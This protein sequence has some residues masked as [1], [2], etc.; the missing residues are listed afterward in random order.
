MRKLKK[1]SK[2]ML[3]VYFTHLLKEKFH[4]FFKT[5]FYK[6]NCEFKERSYKFYSS[7][8]NAKDIVYDVGANFGNRVEAFIKLNAKVVAIEP[9]SA[10]CKYLRKKYKDKIMLVNKAVGSENSEKE[11]YISN[12]SAVSS[13]SKDWVESVKKDR[14][15]EQNWDKSVKCEVVTLDSLI[16]KYSVPAFIKIDVEG[17]ELEVLKGLNK[18]V[19]VISF[20]YTIPE[21][22]E[23]AIQ[24]IKHIKEI[25]GAVECNYSIGESMVLQLK[26]WISDEEMINLISDNRFPNEVGD[27]YVRRI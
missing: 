7:F 12:N 2:S 22:T 15:K 1:I 24:C 16:E 27:I 13:L 20:E 6:E 18:M 17:Y 9:Q 8:I 5:E 19:K 26:S 10:C 4:K 23:N 14:Y 3:G 11:M 21:Q 25:N